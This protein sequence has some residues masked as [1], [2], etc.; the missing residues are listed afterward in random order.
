MTLNWPPTVAAQLIGGASADK[1]TSGE[2]SAP[3]L[4]TKPASGG[5]AIDE[6]AMAVDGLR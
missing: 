5:G 2:T 4:T 1:P 6:L 3:P